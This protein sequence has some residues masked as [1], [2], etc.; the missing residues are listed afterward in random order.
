M[1]DPK[2]AKRAK[3]EKHSK[4]SHKHKHKHKKASSEQAEPP[5]PAPVPVPARAAQQGG[6]DVDPDAEPQPYM[7]GDPLPP[8]VQYKIKPKY[9]MHNLPDGYGKSAGLVIRCARLIDVFRRVSYAGAQ[10]VAGRQG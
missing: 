5:A 1:R 7:L 3:T 2:P 6:G 8:R 4:H 10:V 9:W